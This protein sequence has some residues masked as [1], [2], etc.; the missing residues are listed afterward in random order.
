MLTQLANSKKTGIITVHRNVNYGANLQA[1]ASCK[2]INDAG[3]D[4][5]IIDYLSKELDQDNYLFRWLKHSYD[6]G[7][8]KSL[9]HNLKLN[10]ALALS[11]GAK[12]RRLKKFYS[13]RKNHCK[14]SEKYNTCAEIENTGYDMVICGSDQIWNPDITNG[15]DPLYFGEI[16][17]VAKRISYAASMGKAE[18]SPS[19]AEK[20]V[21][22]IRKLDSCS[23]REP[24]SA[25]YLNGLANCKVQT[26]CD[27]VFL[28]SKA[29]YESLLKKRMI[30][31][32]YVL[33]YS[34]V[35][36]SKMLETAKKYAKE[37]NLK[38]VEICAN[39]DRHQKHTQKAD[40]G[41]IEFLNAIRYAHTVFTNS[42]HGTAFSI[43]FEK[44]FF[45]FNNKHRGS[46]ITSLME[47]AG[48]SEYMLDEERPVLPNEA[49]D[50]SDVHKNLEVFIAS[51]KR[52]LLDAL[53]APKKP[54]VEKNCVGCGVCQTACRQ[55]AIRIIKDDKGFLKSFIDE[56][57]C[58]QCKACYK[59]CPAINEIKTSAPIAT[60]AFK[61]PD[62][63]RKNS[64]SGGAFAALAE[65]V[66]KKG[67]SVYG[68]SLDGDFKLCHKRIDKA[69]DLSLLQGTKYIQS[70]I[71]AVFKALK[72]D[73]LG[74]IPILFSGTPCQVAAVKTFAEKEGLNKE[75]LYLCDI[76]CHGVPSPK[77]FADYIGWLH[78]KE[79]FKKYFFRNK[80]ISWRGDSS[81]VETADARVLHNQNTS[82][83]MNLYYSNNITSDACFACKYAKAE[84]VGDITISDFW[85]I[86]KSNPAFEDALG[87][88]MV[89]INSPKGEKLFE[90]VEGAKEPADFCAAK[91]PQLHHPAEKPD[92]YEAFWQ[93]YKKE[94]FPYAA[95]N[96][97]IPRKNL[98]TVIYNLIKGK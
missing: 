84:R 37:H 97:G 57:K 83:F 33:V 42:F 71:S 36:N 95:K 6:C 77:V 20:V 92:E 13:F 89:L 43:L 53:K 38:L 2:F 1:F 63:L 25:V 29:D 34:I 12:R 81:A 18:Y 50:Y 49:I 9:F 79:D 80:S 15:V 94:G 10:I 93:T 68:A 7:K 90:Q 16:D 44:Q 5:E 22:L 75:N 74:G 96:F 8:T 62:R 47:K 61:A 70:D 78:E 85:G 58:I 86:E 3:F 14:L 40:Y 91:Q 76:I 59:V 24:D 28:L 64:T 67:G 66:I 27:P 65:R 98:K 32:D 55:D 45:V 30:K 46:R 69:G 35:S 82:A 19:E 31:Q 52:F 17:G 60:Y 26:V 87:V 41:P 88:S 56:Q 39:K 73:L 23:V 4:A 11:A 72:E 21:P 48:L 51:S 54:L